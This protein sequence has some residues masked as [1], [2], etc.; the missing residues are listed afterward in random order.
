[1][2]GRG[3]QALH[4][5]KKMLL[6]ISNYGPWQRFRLLTAHSEL[7]LMEYRQPTDAIGYIRAALSLHQQQYLYRDR[8]Q[9]AAAESLRT[10]FDILEMCLMAGGDVNYLRRRMLFLKGRG[11]K[12]EVQLMYWQTSSP[13]PRATF[14]V[15]AAANYS[16]PTP[17]ALDVSSEAGF[18][19]SVQDAL[20]RLP[21]SMVL[22]IVDAE[23]TIVSA[24]ISSLIDAF[25]EARCRVLVSAERSDGG[26]G[27]K[28]REFM[29]HVGAGGRGFIGLASDLLQVF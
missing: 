4:L 19:R 11:R 20:Q 9:F 3:D 6:H 13:S 23:E 28:E 15:R 7:L 27:E 10:A 26:F 8:N 5:Q 24:P 22:C 25:Y 1:M 16:Y 14:F 21:P 2:T 18:V 17:I 12:H 29:P